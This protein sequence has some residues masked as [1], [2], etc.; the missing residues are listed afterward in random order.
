MRRA[1]YISHTGMSEPLGQSQVVP[2]VAGLTRSGWKIDIVSFEPANAPTRDLDRTREQLASFGVGYFPTRRSPSHALGV[3]FMEAG[4]GLLRLFARAARRRPRIIHARSYLP[5]AVARLV[6]AALPGSR[7]LFDLRGL[8]GEEYIDSGRWT[9]ERL[10]YRLLKRA[11]RNMLKHAA[12]IVVLTEAHRRWLR[13][14]VR[15]LSPSIPSEVIP[16]C[17]DVDR[18][19][20]DPEGRA[21]ARRVLGAGDR[22][23]L[24]F[25]GTLNALSCR[26]AMARLFAM[27]RHRRP[28]LFAVYTP[29]DASGLRQLLTEKGLADADVQIRAVSPFDMPAFLAAA[30]AAVSFM[31]P[32]FSKKGCSPTKVPE[33]LA[34]GLPVVMNRG[35]GDSDQLI[36]DVPAVIDAGNLLDGEL[37]RAADALLALELAG[38]ARTARAAAERLFS[39]EQ[40]GV[41]RYR[42]LYERLA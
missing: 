21:R 4:E 7:F 8:A 22:F 2:Y 39:L 12:G 27:I 24:A 40:V 25:S 38:T 34:V 11:E 42:A 35:I 31:K 36:D 3:K 16:C 23:V 30:D 20:P 37:E 32:A 33:Y 14:E 18:F 19:K 5:G 28:A 15:L 17:V 41:A 1:L 29:S 6:S 9:P 13:D 26:D 10:E